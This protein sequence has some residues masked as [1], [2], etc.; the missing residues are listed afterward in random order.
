MQ[1]ET[2]DQMKRKLQRL[3]H[4][5]AVREAMQNADKESDS[6]EAKDIG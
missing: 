2:L 6:T 1:T 4:V 3:N 5:N